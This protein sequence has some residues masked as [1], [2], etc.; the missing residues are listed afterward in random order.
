MVGNVLSKQRGQRG[1]S[2]RESGLDGP[3]RDVEFLGDVVHGEPQVL[4]HD[5]LTLRQRQRGQRASHVHPLAARRR[6]V[7]GGPV[8]GERPQ[9][10]G[11]SCDD[12][13]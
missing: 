6:R 8:P 1:A 5:D 2:A 4:K 10:G 11:R 9:N 7:G 12:G 13:Y 3:G